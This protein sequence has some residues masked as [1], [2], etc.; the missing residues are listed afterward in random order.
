MD[1]TELPPGEGDRFALITEDNYS[2]YLWI[3]SIL[4]LIYSLLVIVVRLHIKWN[5]FGADDVTAAVATVLQ[6]GQVVPL[7]LAMKHGLGK[8]NDL[9][10]A[11]QLEDA[12]KATF[13]AQ[14]FLILALAAAKGS[15]A[16]LMLRLFTRDIKAT[17]RSWILCNTTLA[18]TVA[19]GIGAIVAVSVSC[20][21]SNF[22]NISSQCG[23]RVL[24]WRIIAAFDIF[25]EVLLVTLPVLF[26]WPI[27]MKGYIKLQV[28]VAFGFRLP[29]IGF[30]IAHLHYVSSYANSNNV[31]KDIIPA[32]VYQQF[33]LFWSLLAATIP[34]LK[35]FMR[36]FNS[37]FGME[38]DLDGYG[39][40]YGSNGTYPLESLQNAT[41]SNGAV[42]S[43]PGVRARTRERDDVT[44]GSRSATGSTRDRRITPLSDIMR[45]G[46][47][48]LIIQKEVQWTVRHDDAGTQRR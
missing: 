32:L 29:V 22:I 13:A 17:R 44:F 7:F 43:R 20:S 3:A 28:I 14:I 40:A 19:W 39:S 8:S 18:L 24:R 36:S 37:G 35:A 16:A 11:Q 6:L 30:A 25:L 4:G 2:G 1:S 34:T 9:L 42:V 33:E 45:E 27:Q 15:V 48:E 47:Q 21:T 31:S 12:G 5:L 10:S 26:I 38:I 23:D 46:S 41:S